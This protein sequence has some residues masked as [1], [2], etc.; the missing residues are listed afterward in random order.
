MWVY[1]RLRVSYGT[2]V[3]EQVTYDRGS[4]IQRIARPV[5]EMPDGKNYLLLDDCQIHFA[6]DL[7]TLGQKVALCDEQTEWRERALAAKRNA[8]NEDALRDANRAIY[9]VDVPKA[10]KPQGW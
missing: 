2:L 4:L 1:E 6:H 9:S 8:K 10:P 3:Y 5:A 7:L